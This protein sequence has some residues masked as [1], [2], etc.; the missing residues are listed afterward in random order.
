MDMSI[1]AEVE[2]HMWGKGGWLRPE[3]G[4][5]ES[6][7]GGIPQWNPFT[8]TRV[9][10]APRGEALSCPVA[11][12]PAPKGTGFCTTLHDH[13]PCCGLQRHEGRLHGTELVG[14]H[15]CF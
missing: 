8:V 5:S 13:P 7:K 14:T 11:S 10:K 12:P 4:G 2:G 9:R 6:D 15:R 3:G 1:W